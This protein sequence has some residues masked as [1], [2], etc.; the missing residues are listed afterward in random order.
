MMKSV[1][2]RRGASSVRFRRYA[3]EPNAIPAANHVS[4]DNINRRA[5]LYHSGKHRFP[6]GEHGAWQATR[7]RPVHKS[8]ALFRKHALSTAHVR[9]AEETGCGRPASTLSHSCRRRRSR[10]VV[11]THAPNAA[12]NLI[13]CFAVADPPAA[14]P[15]SKR[16]RVGGP[17]NVHDALRNSKRYRIAGDNAEQLTN[18]DRYCNLSFASNGSFPYHD[19]RIWRA[20]E[21]S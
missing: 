20:G 19:V 5:N 12:V 21:S 6:R 18:I 14:G 7:R 13:A 9:H 8:Q 16:I 15:E 4:R 17:C 2:S 10:V 1:R 3:N 11:T